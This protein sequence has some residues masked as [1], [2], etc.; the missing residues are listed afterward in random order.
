MST[1]IPK[2]II[3]K[4]KVAY[5]KVRDNYKRYKNAEWKWE[6]V[7]NEIDALKN[8]GSFN[9][10]KTVALKKNIKYG[11][12]IRKYAEWNKNKEK[13]IDDD[14]RG[15][16][17]KIFTESEER[18]L[19]EYIVK[20]FIEC[21]LIFS[22][23]HLKFL[24]IQKY[25]MLRKEKDKNYI[26]DDTFTLSDGWV[27]DYKRKWKLSSL[28]TKLNRKGIKIDASELDKFYEECRQAVNTIDKKY[29]FNLD[30]TF[31][32]I[33]G[34]NLTVIGITNSD[35]R[36]V[37]SFM[38]KKAG[39]TAT[40]IISHA[41]E[42]MTPYIILKGKTKKSLAKISDV[43]DNDI[44]KKF[45]YSGWMTVSILSDIIHDINSKTNGEAS[46][47]IMDKYSVHTDE[48]IRNKAAELNIKLIYVPTGK[49]ATNQPLDV[50]INGPIKSIGRSISN[51]IFMK[52]PFDDYTLVN[53][54][55]AMIDA[56]NNISSETII[57]SFN[58]ACYI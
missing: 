29:I 22:N 40:F 19:Y 25:H 41:G 26:K 54:I 33:C 1:V 15:G 20:V 16:H 58:Y 18:E 8:E 21:N 36:K 14:N 51:K 4:R 50:S 30:E 31:W 28:K 3:K 38:N 42:F 53:S 23:E 52:D 24:A 44:V 57:K 46:V 9:Y 34:T 45:S 43:C 2:K 56:K 27:S 13:Y 12:L 10:I 17:N 39:F 11:T 55:K 49:T 5:P 32:R 37:E 35:Y 47:L 48:I 7:F 6:T